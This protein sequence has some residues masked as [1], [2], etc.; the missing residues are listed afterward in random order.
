MRKFYAD[1]E[2]A[3][4]IDLLKVGTVRYA[5]HSSTFVQCL[6]FTMLGTD[7]DEPRMEGVFTQKEIESKTSKTRTFLTDIA[8]DPDVV[9][10]AHNAFFDRN[11]WHYVMHKKLGYPDIPIERWRCTMAKC[12]KYSLP[13]S[14]SKAALALELET[15]KD[16][17]GQQSMLLLCRPHK[18][19]TYSCDTHLAP[20]S[21]PCC[22]NSYLV[23]FHTP[24][25]FPTLFEK[26]YK[27]CLDD[28]RAM[29][30]LD[31]KLPDLS[32]NQQKIWEMD[33]RLNQRGLL[34][35]I[36]LVEKAIEL[37]SAYK[38][39][40]CGEYQDITSMNKKPTQRKDL[41]KWLEDQDVYV[42][43]TKKSTFKPMLATGRLMNNVQRVMEISL[44]SNKSSLAK[45]LK[46]EQLASAL[47]ILTELIQYHAAHT[48]RWGGRGV[49]PQ[50]LPRPSIK[51][52]PMILWCIENCTYEGFKMMYGDK[53]AEAL[54]SAL[55]AM[56]IA[57]PGH[58]FN[59]GDYKQVE[60]RIAA[61]LTNQEWK[62]DM[63]RAGIDTYCKAAEPIVGYPVTPDM[64]DDRQ[65]GK[66]SELGLG[67]GGGINAFVNTA[68]IY[69]I[70]LRKIAKPILESATAK[71]LDTAQY[72]YTFYQKTNDEECVDVSTGMACDVI[73]QRWRAANPEVTE[74]WEDLEAAACSA[75]ETPGK[76]IRA[77]RVVWYMNGPFLICQ[78]PSK[79]FIAYFKPELH[80]D[81]KGNRYFS[82]EPNDPKIKRKYSYGG[83]IFENVVQAVAY[84]VMS[85][86]LV[87]AEEYGFTPALTVHDE[88]VFEDWMHSLTLTSETLKEVLEE[89]LPWY[90]GLPIEVDITRTVRYG[91]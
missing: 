29:V 12:Y 33:Q 31:C 24:A 50:N 85:A 83:F 3:S 44:A 57:R 27:Y 28:V 43:N 8:N 32:F 69:G 49:Q 63:Y 56:I 72:C 74:Y 61:W 89:E 1:F 66:A 64:V 4:A 45:Y 80:E 30:E 46:M 6:G 76:R 86:A 84:D 42:I 82:W 23:E 40:L 39:D 37:V 13:G 67:F 90:D 41:K 65:V 79:N 5:S 59:S 78:L 14:L 60:A 19:P 71:E 48:G 36:P 91:K 62:L 81:Q 51:D 26:H 2:T 58:V 7:Y 35:D 11:I 87:R 68:K 38:A 77:K 52:I 88:G 70:D 16:L 22:D 34:L 20:F 55:R 15:Q 54:A 21:K 53:L 10:V 9:I 75:I 25:H 18:T 17:V 47:H 73:K